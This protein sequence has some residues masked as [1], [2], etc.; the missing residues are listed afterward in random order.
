MIQQFTLPAPIIQDLAHVETIVQ[1]RLNARQA[2]VHLTRKYLGDVADRQLRAALVLLAA[3]LGSYQLEQVQ[4]AAAAA[5]LIHRAA[6]VHKDLVNDAQRR[7]GQASSTN[8]WEHGPALMLGDYFFA[9]AAGEMARAPD[10]RVI[11][12]YSQAVMRISEGGLAPVLQATPLDLALTQYFY[13]IG[14]R[15]AALFA[16]ACRAGVALAGGDDERIERVGEFGYQLGL[17]FQVMD[18]ALDYSLPTP[19]GAATPA[20]GGTDLRR[21]IITLPFI[22][23]VEHA[24]DPRLAHAIDSDDP[25]VLAHA[26]VQVQQHGV[27]H[28]YRVARQLASEACAHL[29]GLP[30]VPARHL[31]EQ[32]SEQIVQQSQAHRSLS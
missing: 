7:R 12:Y 20:L 19:N 23:A 32:L 26:R 29:A 17:A 28:A 5:E 31:L 8:Q 10:A 14:C 25:D 21:G 18:D 30:A 4:H 22:Y 24:S 2:V 1:A 16:A 3:Q 15:T 6:L 13:K 11:T 27:P 9:L